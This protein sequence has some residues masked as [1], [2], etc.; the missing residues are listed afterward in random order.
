[1]KFRS[2]ILALSLVLPLPTA[3]FAGSCPA[4]MA[5]IDEL[6]A[7][8]PQVDD[9]VLAEVKEARERG[10]QLHKEGNHGESVEELNHA[11]SLLGE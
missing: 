8:N 5:E 7:A 11:L 4:L 2:L 10:E 6:L 1:M 9:E 3:A